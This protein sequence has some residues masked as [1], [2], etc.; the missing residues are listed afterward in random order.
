MLFRV[1]K[2]AIL[3]QSYFLENS[4]FVFLNLS[5]FAKAFGEFLNF[6]GRSKIFD[7]FLV[8]SNIFWTFLVFLNLFQF[9]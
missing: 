4:D 9:S 1:R 7:D 8:F 2:K 5:E 3:F 6:Q